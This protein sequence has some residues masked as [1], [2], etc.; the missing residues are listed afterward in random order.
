LQAQIVATLLLGVERV[1]HE[2]RSEPATEIVTAP[3]SCLPAPPPPAQGTGLGDLFRSFDIE[4]RQL[5]IP[6]TYLYDA[7]SDSAHTARS[8]P[9]SS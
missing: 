8:G 3:Q 4:N 5:L 2:R 9:V 6:L 7:R 1:D